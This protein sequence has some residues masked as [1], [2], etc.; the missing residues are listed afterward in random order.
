MLVHRRI[1]LATAVLAAVLWGASPALAQLGA[2]LFIQPFP[3]AY[4]GD[5][6]TN[7]SIGLLTISNSSPSF[8]RQV[9]ID[10]RILRSP[11]MMPILS[12]SSDPQLIPPGP[13]TTM[14]N[15]TQFLSLRN[16]TYNAS[17][18]GLVA[19][20]GR[21]PEGEYIARIDIRDMS[22]TP[23]VSDVAS[24]PF[25]IVYPPSPVL[26]YPSDGDTIIQPNPVFQWVPATAPP[27]FAVQYAL[28]VIEVLP[29]QVPAQALAANDIPQYEDARITGTTVIYPLNALPLRKGTTY[30][31][32]VQA[33][34]QNGYPVSTNNGYSQFFT[35]TFTDGIIPPPPPP[36]PPPPVADCLQLNAATP[37]NGGAWKTLTIPVFGVDVRPAIMRSGLRRV[38]LRVWEMNRAGEASATVTARQPVVSASID[39][40]SPGL[41]LSPQGSGSLLQVTL[42][43]SRADMHFAPVVQ[44]SYMWQVDLAYDPRAIR[45]DSTTCIDS[46]ETSALYTFVYDTTSAEPGPGACRDVCSANEPSDK[47]PSP[48]PC[49]PG[50][51][52]KAGR[53]TMVLTEA[54]GT[55]AALTGKGEIFIPMLRARL[56]VEFAGIAVNRSHQLINGQINA[57][58]AGESTLTP[59]EANGLSGAFDLSNEKIEAIHALASTATRTLKGLTG[60]EAMTLPLGLDNEIGGVRYVVGI[61]GAVFTP[62]AAYLNAAMSYPLPDLGPGIGVGLGAR[63]I[64]FSPDGFGG[65]GNVTLS[66][67]SDLGYRNDESWSFA[68]LAPRNGSKG[69]AVTF[70]CRGF[71]EFRVSAEVQ[72][73]RSWLRPFPTDDGTSKVTASFETVV[74]RGGNFIA[75]AGMD[76][77]EITGAPG[78]VLEAQDLTFDRSADE[79]PESIV[80]PAG[81]RGAHDNSFTGF[82]IK[83]ASVSL[84][85]QLRTFDATQPP[86]IAVQNLIIT[87]GG[88]TG[89]F[90]AENVFMYPQADFGE[91]GGSLD[92]LGVEVVNS[93]LQRG[94][95]TGRIKMPISE[96]PLRYTATLARPPAGDT[97]RTL[98]YQFVL[99]P[100]DT[101]SADIWKARITLSPASTITIGNDN[102]YR[103]FVASAELSGSVTVAGTIGGIP[104]IDFPGVAFQ[105]LRLQS[106][107]PYFQNGIWSFASPE[108]KLAGFPLTIAGV[109]VASDERDGKD[110]TGLRFRA[111]INLSPGTSAISGTTAITLWGALERDGGAQRFSFHGA[112][113]DSIAVSA[114][115]GPV[116][117]AGNVGLYREDPVFGSG[118]RGAVRADILKRI[119]VTSSIQFGNVRGFRYFYVDAKGAFH[120]GIAFG[121]TGV[122]FYGFGGGFWWNMRREGTGDLPVPGAS[123]VAGD[124]PGATASGLRFVPDEG[125]L[126]FKG[127][128]VLGTHPSP[129]AFNADVA[130]EVELQR[131]STGV[132]L[133]RITLRGDGYMMA[134]IAER[135]KAKIRCAADITYDFPT[136]TLHGVFAAVIDAPPVSGSGQLVL[137]IEPKTWY[138]KIGEPANPINVRLASWLSTDG[139]LMLGRDLPPPPPLP[140]RV[141]AILGT[142]APDRDT[143]IAAGNGFAM[144]ASMSFSTGRQYYFIFYGDVSAGGGFDIA[145]L[146]QN[147]CEGINGWQAQGRLYAYVDASVGLHIDIGFYVYYPC[148]PW[149]CARLCR[150]CRNG[151]VGYKGDFEILGIHAAALLEV[152]GPRPLWVAGTVA[153]RYSILGGLVKGNCS[154]RFSKGTECRL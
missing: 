128:V 84:P 90:R 111:S 52:I 5:W 114:D 55:G 48:L 27:G 127:M 67:A 93:S 61:I 8:S 120:P 12:G 129:V 82:F 70:D 26:I 40:G 147:R 35:F 108:K 100:S 69:C 28:R 66:L 7:G 130:L 22:G 89:S 138:L 132:S 2:S 95:M 45:T 91:W 103:K 73:P 60:V 97:A 39:T 15:N 74:G 109:S 137:H 16:V 135:E 80:F 41:T 136:S 124:A 86:Q 107:R 62:T 20:S 152:G 10:L 142:Q 32:R 102:P 44:R 46:V 115:L 50:D 59:E 118:F 71:K 99:Q 141:R 98:N 64:C 51:T 18:K 1:R 140:A 116:S 68:F 131:T 77:C 144:G 4:P 121:T 6:Q 34:D 23:L 146:Q 53:F 65:D 47:T 85:P 148:G 151:Y 106:V 101:L 63:R 38:E 78:F 110:L 25:T 3:S 134:A 36:P 94:W 112:E 24:L 19:R 31:W 9:R 30:V 21:L 125:S 14:L 76:R 149:W 96:T 154:F 87:R 13:S 123:A 133:G 153:G 92:T 33:L 54:Q 139:Y 143:R 122:G 113:L 119:S 83:R 75:T 42:D 37:E 72:F 104:H 49:A 29:G 57:S 126:G 117:I 88:I 43:T 105:N 17:L 81:Y 145:L 150:W 56:A 58:L 79:N 11:D